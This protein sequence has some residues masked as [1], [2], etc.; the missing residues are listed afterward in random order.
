LPGGRN[1][2]VLHEAREPHASEDVSGRSSLNSR[3]LFSEGAAEHFFRNPQR[4]P[5]L[6]KA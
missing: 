3:S 4:S 1:G 6:L 2:I 5:I